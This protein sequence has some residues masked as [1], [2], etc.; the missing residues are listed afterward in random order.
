MKEGTKV[1][2]VDAD[3]QHLQAEVLAGATD[4]RATLRVIGK[5]GNPFT[6]QEVVYARAP[7]AMYASYM[8]RQDEVET[9]RTEL[10]DLG[11]RLAGM[12]IKL[13]FLLA[14]TDR[15]TVGDGVHGAE[16]TGAEQPENFEL[17]EGDEDQV[18]YLRK[19]VDGARAAAEH[20]DRESVKLQA[21]LHIEQE[22]STELAGQVEEL[23]AKLARATQGSR[24]SAAKPANPGEG[25]GLTGQ[26]A[27]GA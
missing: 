4:G 21:Q 20:N 8:S 17:E 26:G 23:Q 2:Y 24:D 6:A 3:G 16:A 1:V 10:V 5:N 13:R 22:K 19:Q 11:K 25:G 14:M 9:R 12:G 27:G 18:E 7:R 15:P